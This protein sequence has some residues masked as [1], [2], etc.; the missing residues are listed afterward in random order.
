MTERIN[1]KLKDKERE[2]LH[3]KFGDSPSN[4][5]KGRFRIFERKVGDSKLYL[6]K[7]TTNLIVY[8]GRNWLIQ[9]AFNT[10]LVSRPGWKSRYI[11]WLGIGSGGAPIG[12]PL[13]PTDP[14][15]TDN[16]LDTQLPLGSSANIITLSGKD[17]H[18]FDPGYPKILHDGAVSG[19][20]GLSTSCSETDPVDAG[21]YYCDS[22]LIAESKITI[23]ADEGNGAGSQNINECGLYVSPSNDTGYGFSAGDIQLFARVTFSTIVKDSSRELI[24]SWYV[25]F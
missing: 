5:L 11:S 7:D 16:S 12:D 4:Q 3:D 22:F 25:Y 19:D 17:Y 6:V 18:T 24:F 2:N 8:Q 20:P 21:S 23:G 9:R 15:L 14:D 13:V 1:I 10:D